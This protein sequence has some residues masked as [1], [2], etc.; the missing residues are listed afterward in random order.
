MKPH[1]VGDSDKDRTDDWLCIGNVGGW[2]TMKKVMSRAIL[3]VSALLVLLAGCSFEPR[4]SGRGRI[5]ARTLTSG[6]D[7]GDGARR[8]AGMPD[9]TRDIL[10]DG[11]GFRLYLERGGKELVAIG[12]NG[13]NFIEGTVTD[14]IVIEDLEPAYYRLYVSLTGAPE[15]EPFEVAK[16]G[17][18]DPIKVTAGET[19]ETVITILP[20]ITPFK[21]VMT[22]QN[23]WAYHDGYDRMYRLEGNT[24]IY[25]DEYNDQEMEAQI[26]PGY[27]ARSLSLGLELG[28][29]ESS[30]AWV[31][32]DS[33]VLRLPYYN[34]GEIVPLAETVPAEQALATDHS[35]ALHLPAWYEDGE[36]TLDKD[37][38]LM[39]YQGEG[40]LKGAFVELVY[41]E[42][43][44]EDVVNFDWFDFFDGICND[45]SEDYVPGFDL[46]QNIGPL[47][48]GFL[49]TDYF[50][51]SGYS[52]SYFAYV[53]P[54]QA[55]R[56]LD[57]DIPPA[58]RIGQDA[59]EAYLQDV[60]VGNIE[61][62]GKVSYEWIKNVIFTEQNSISLSDWWDADTVVN[63]VATDSAG[64]HDVICIG[65]NR[66]LYLLPINEQGVMSP[67]YTPSVMGRN[68]DIVKVRA[69]SRYDEQYG[70]V[71]YSAA[72]AR[73]GTLLIAEDFGILEEYPFCAGLPM[74]PL[75]L[76]IY[77]TSY[78][79]G[80]LLIDC[81]NVIVIGE[82]ENGVRTVVEGTVRTWERGLET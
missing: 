19:A 6:Q 47:D 30:E 60:A 16:Y 72:I 63:S 66:G 36:Q 68:Y 24:L 71:T 81:L 26:P 59:V 18:S 31:N 50:K 43:L 51:S 53:V 8:D 29:F 76:S 70:N 13:Q 56:A 78:Q 4:S 42:Q 23:V 27:N 37:F 79:K 46:F 21:T 41:D 62:G 77:E 2:E 35:G 82:D 61:D 12:E 11:V 28:Y 75:D 73:N 58:F 55:L 40:R 48:T 52:G 33:G 45:E 34:E 65:T 54:S 15:N 3:A 22:G 74:N 20:G 25:I 67:G 64:V 10:P 9:G 5:V 57:N 14:P 39:F 44:Q 32:S 38:S 69:Y 17:T 1:R 49:F 80:N 7:N